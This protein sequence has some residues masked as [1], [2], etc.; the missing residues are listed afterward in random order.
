[1]L[2]KKTLTLLR[3]LS[4]S[5]QTSYHGDNEVEVAENWTDTTLTFQV[6]AWPSVFKSPETSLTGQ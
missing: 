1:M 3:I 2:V 5:D 6:A 4:L